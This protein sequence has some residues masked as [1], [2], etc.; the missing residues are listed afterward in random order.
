MAGILAKAWAGPQAAPVRHRH[1]LSH[2]L[3]LGMLISSGNVLI[4]LGPS[5][6]SLGWAGLSAR[7]AAL[8]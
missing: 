8:S 2:A 5:P 4:D 7:Q 6:A 3:A 1:G